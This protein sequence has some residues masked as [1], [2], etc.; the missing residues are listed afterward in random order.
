MKNFTDILAIA[1]VVGGVVAAIAGY[2]KA[3]S[4]VKIGRLIVYRDWGD[5]FKAS[6]WI[7]LVPYGVLS[8][9][10]DD[11]GEWPA[12]TLGVIAIAVGA[13][14]FWWSCAGAYRYNSGSRRGLALFARF[15]V[16][17]LI[18]FALGKLHENFRQYR[19]GELGVIRGILIPALIF[20]WVFHEFIQPMIGTRCHAASR[21]GE[22]EA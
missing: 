1:A 20:A 2:A 9:L 8:I 17:L 12:R 10:F 4:E 13:V 21:L 3:L 18:V 16:T 5:L 19:R 6:A 7:L 15:A 14:S 22:L 11:G